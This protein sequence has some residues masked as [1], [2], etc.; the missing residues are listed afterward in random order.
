MK[1]QFFNFL[2]FSPFTTKMSKLQD[3]FQTTAKSAGQPDFTT[4]FALEGTTLRLNGNC[5]ERFAN[6]VTDNSFAVICSALE[7]TG[8]LV[9]EIDASFALLSDEGALALAE[10]LRKNAHVQFVNVAHNA[11]SHRGCAAIADALLL[12]SSGLLGISLR[13]NPIGEEGGLA[14]ATMLKANGTLMSLDIGQCELTTKSLVGLCIALGPHPALCSLK[15][16]KPLFARAGPQDLATVVQ[17][18]SQ[19]LRINKNLSELSMEFF[20]LTDEHL[21]TLL[22]CLVQCDTLTHISFA[23]NKF[24]RD[25]GIL[26][27]RLLG[28]RP[29]LEKLCI[30]G[31][32]IGNVG[33][34]ALASSLKNHHSIQYLSARR[35]ALG[36]VGLASI[37]EAIVLAPALQTLL[38]FENNEFEQLATANFSSNLIRSRLQKLT[39]VDF[40]V[41]KNPDGSAVIVQV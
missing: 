40:A 34:Q 6:R 16:D 5:R 3:L 33:A 25:G 23:G 4:P 35:C 41:E 7:K 27:G 37:A 1:I 9:T 28:R 8:G 18:L 24:S 10:L 12:P 17:H 22:P 39:S 38:L 31:N 20:G 32:R 14:L 26:L 13:G 30:D 36:D 2:K 19:F 15:I 11:I 21:Q 29:D